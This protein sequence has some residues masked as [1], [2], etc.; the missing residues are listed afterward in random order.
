MRDG[1]KSG[2]SGAICR[3]PVTIDGVNARISSIYVPVNARIRKTFL[4]KLVEQKWIHRDDILGGDFNCV[5]NVTLDTSTIEGG[6]PY[7]NNHG[8]KLESILSAAGLHDTYRQ[9]HGDMATG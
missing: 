9:F 1:A 8:V 6:T 7:V 3:V 4:E 2:L 5:A